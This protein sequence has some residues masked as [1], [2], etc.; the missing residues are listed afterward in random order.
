MKIQYRT[1]LRTELHS[2]FLDCPIHSDTE[3]ETAALLVRFSDL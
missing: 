3:S 1:G 2:I